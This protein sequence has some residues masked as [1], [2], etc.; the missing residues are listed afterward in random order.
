MVGRQ[1]VVVVVTVVVA[2]RGR[3]NSKESQMRIQRKADE[4]NCKFPRC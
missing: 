4:K 3:I 2:V 1:V